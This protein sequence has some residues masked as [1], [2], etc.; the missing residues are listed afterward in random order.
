LRERCLKMKELIEAQNPG[1][2]G[3]RTQMGV[4]QSRVELYRCKW[5]VR[6][7]WRNFHSKIHS[8][9]IFESC[10]CG[11][12][13]NAHMKYRCWKAVDASHRTPAMSQLLNSDIN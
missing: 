1:Q 12:P 9:S 11:K 4:R 13:I 5:R 6:S 3:R 8:F 2:E 7:E 10:L